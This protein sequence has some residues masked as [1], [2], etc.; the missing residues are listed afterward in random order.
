MKRKHEDWLDRT[1]EEL[2]KIIEVRNHARVKVINRN[3][4]SAKTELRKHNTLLQKI[5][6]ELKDEWRA[7]KAAE[8]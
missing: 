5:C 6:R 1:D 7:D 8:I 4:R 3:T 2:G